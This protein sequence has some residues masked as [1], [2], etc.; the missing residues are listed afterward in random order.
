MCCG[1]GVLDAMARQPIISNVPMALAVWHSVCHTAAET[2]A[3]FV[4]GRWCADRHWL[5]TEMDIINIE[6]P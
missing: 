3:A 4:E 6:S 5:C 1:A 2:A